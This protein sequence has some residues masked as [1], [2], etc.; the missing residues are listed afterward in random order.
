MKSLDEFL[1][2]TKYHF[3]SLGR[4]KKKKTSFSQAWHGDD[5]FKGVV[6]G[7]EERITTQIM[8]ESPEDNTVTHDC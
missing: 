2:A 8:P 1:K 6:L 5:L 7:K 3:I 4:K